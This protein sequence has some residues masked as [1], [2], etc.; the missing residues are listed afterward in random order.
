M[1]IMPLVGSMLFNLFLPCSSKE[2]WSLVKPFWFWN[3]LHMILKYYVLGGLLKLWIFLK[4]IVRCFLCLV[5]MW[6]RCTMCMVAVLYAEHFPAH[7]WVAFNITFNS[8]GSNIVATSTFNSSVSS[9]FLCEESYHLL[10][11]VWIFWSVFMKIIHFSMEVFIC[12]LEIHFETKQLW[13]GITT[14][15]I[16]TKLV[17]ITYKKSV[18]MRV[19]WL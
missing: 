14:K 19:A 7:H 5:T 15:L 11:T 8:A 16:R 18:S 6:W 3:L 9:L 2:K 17:Y 1:I 12:C 4:V 10:D 13:A